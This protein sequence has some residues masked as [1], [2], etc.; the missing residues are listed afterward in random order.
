MSYGEEAETEYR[1]GTSLARMTITNHSDFD[2]MCENKSPYNFYNGINFF[3]IKAHARTTIV[4][5]TLEQIPEFSLDLLVHN[6]LVAPGE[7]MA[8]TIPVKDLLAP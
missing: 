3:T 8:L 1:E 6:A 5:K 2:F 7:S 4:V